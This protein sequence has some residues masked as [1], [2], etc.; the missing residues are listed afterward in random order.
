M[1]VAVL[2][3]SNKPSRYSYKAV[4][5]LME[6]GHKVFPVHKVIKEVLGLKVYPNLSE[7]K[8]PIDILTVYVNECVSTNVEK[9]ILQLKP[10]KIIFNPDTEN[11]DLAD[12]ARAQGIEVVFGCTL[13]MLSTNSF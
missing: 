6:K 8:E 3:A 4:E 5:R 11:F 1:N 13:V 2:G 10:K 7:I 9:E 12:K